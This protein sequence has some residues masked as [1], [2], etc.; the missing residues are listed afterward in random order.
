[1]FKVILTPVFLLLW[2]VRVEGRQ[3]VPK[4]GPAILAANHQSFSDSLFL[5]LVLPRKVTYVAKAEY[6]DR[7]RTAWFF[8]AAGQIPIRRDGGSVS[9]RALDTAG[10]V[11]QAG[12]LLGIYPEGTRSP[13]ERLHRGHTGVMRLARTCGVPVI[14]VGLSGT[15]HVQP[16]GR[17]LLR[18]FRPVTVRFGPPI[19]PGG[20]AVCGDGAPGR[21]PDAA[22]AGEVEAEE[23]RALTDILMARIAA[24]S[25]QAYVDD[26]ATRP[27]RAPDVG[28][29]PAPA[30]AEHGG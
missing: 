7:W 18:P 12:R 26:Y 19:D 23:L 8:R 21:G 3:H 11:L 9:Q 13:D 29:R 2:R 16:P 17:M 20:A 15:R 24:L 28:P 4:R 1:M 27:A 30:P 14:P 25:G 6:F 5:P 10:E 22:D